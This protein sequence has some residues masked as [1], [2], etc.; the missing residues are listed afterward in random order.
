MSRILR[1]APLLSLMTF[2][3]AAPPHGQSPAVELEGHFARIE[4]EAA[5]V[6]AAS[7]PILPAV[8]ALASDRI[9]IAGAAERMPST[10]REEVD[11][12]VHVLASAPNLPR[13]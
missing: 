10:A 7:V 5:N 11:A 2:L 1:R 3:A 6:A 12:S 13:R 9:A 8:C 4:A